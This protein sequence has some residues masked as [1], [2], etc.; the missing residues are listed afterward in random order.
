M[1]KQK[2][3]NEYAVPHH[4]T[5]VFCHRILL[6]RFYNPCGRTRAESGLASEGR[7]FYDA[8]IPLNHTSF[9]N[10]AL[11]FTGI[12]ACIPCRQVTAPMSKKPRRP[13]ASAAGAPATERRPPELVKSPKTGRQPMKRREMLQR[14]G[15]GGGVASRKKEER[16][17]GFFTSIPL[18]AGW[19]WWV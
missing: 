5:I 14:Y 7:L 19:R 2:E 16:N 1:P 3:Y 6:C 17:G 9:F 13:A 15:A 8:R 18:A 4:Q 10:L 12:R 11:L